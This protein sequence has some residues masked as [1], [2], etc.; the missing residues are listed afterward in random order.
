MKC[1]KGLLNVIQ[2]AFWTNK[3]IA[4]RLYFQWQFPVLLPQCPIHQQHLLS[5]WSLCDL[6]QNTVAIPDFP[7]SWNKTDPVSIILQSQLFTNPVNFCD[8]ISIF[9]CRLWQ[10]CYIRFID[11]SI[12][13]VQAIQHSQSNAVPKSNN[14]YHINQ[15]GVLQLTC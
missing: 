2:C 3:T 12:L 8:K 5:W 10:T 4:H 13:S 14:R 11:Q 9:M 1:Y 6:S 15:K 7:S